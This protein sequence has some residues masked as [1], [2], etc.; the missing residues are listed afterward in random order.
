MYSMTW[1]QMLTEGGIGLYLF[2]A[3]VLGS[4]AAASLRIDDRELRRMDWQ[5]ALEK[6]DVSWASL[7]TAFDEAVARGDGTAALRTWSEAHSAALRARH[8]EGLLAVGEARLKVAQTADDEKAAIAKAREAYLAALFRARQD[9]SL[10]GVIR[11]AEA[12]EALGD[13]DLAN[14]IRGTWPTGAASAPRERERL[15]VEP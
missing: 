8:W 12:F 14:A 4:L 9:G 11:S 1:R 6:D 7:L 3:V 10:E 5:G 13:V 15:A 2:G